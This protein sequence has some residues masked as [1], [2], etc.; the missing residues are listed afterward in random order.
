MFLK[1]LTTTVKKHND[2]YQ[3]GFLYIRFLNDYIEIKTEGAQKTIRITNDEQSL[4]TYLNYLK[5]FTLVGKVNKPQIRIIENINT[6][7]KRCS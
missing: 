3:N 2:W 7:C 1:M 5:N 6:D 4:Y